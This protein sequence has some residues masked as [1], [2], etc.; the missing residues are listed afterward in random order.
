V[1]EG[2]IRLYSGSIL[3]AAR[4]TEAVSL[5]AARSLAGVDEDEKG[6]RVQYHPSDITAQP[7]LRLSPLEESRVRGLTAKPRIKTLPFSRPPHKA[8]LSIFPMGVTQP[9]N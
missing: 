2:S 8:Q 6:R 5:C 9:G 1:T 4:M 7:R 3:A